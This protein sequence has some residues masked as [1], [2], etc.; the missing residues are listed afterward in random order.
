MSGQALHAPW[1]NCWGGDI[2]MTILVSL[3]LLNIRALSSRMV[4]GMFLMRTSQH[5][6]TQTVISVWNE[7]ECKHYKLF[8]DKVGGEKG[9][10]ASFLWEDQPTSI[11]IPQSSSTQYIWLF[12]APITPPNLCPS[13]LVSCAA[14]RVFP[15][16]R[17]LLRES[18]GP[19]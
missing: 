13:M 10:H 1:N 9:V 4:D 12:P 6:G 8:Q 5:A 7:N 14:E 17:S 18:H 19:D 16:P 3:S 11:I 15:N 2:K